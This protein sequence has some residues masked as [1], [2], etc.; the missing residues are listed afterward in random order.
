MNP[1]ERVVRRVDAFQQRH[2]VTSFAFGVVKK[3]G[4]DRAGS[5]AALIAYYSFLAI[6]PLLLL[7]VTILGFVA[8][9][10]TDFQHRL[11]HSAVADFPIIGNQIAKN[12]KSLRASGLGLA[13]SLIGL[14]WGSLG[15]T[16]AGQH[17]MAQVWNVPGVERPGFLPRL[18]RGAS[19]IGV[20]GLG[21]IATTIFS[22]FSAFNST[23]P[24]LRGLSML[25]SVLLNVA[26]S[27]AAFRLLT[28]RAIP[29]RKLVPGA[30]LAAL[31]WSVLQ[32]IGGYLVS[33]RL[34]Q[35]SEV[36]GLFAIVL[37]LL[38]WLSLGAQITLYAAELNVVR[39]RRLYPRSIVQPPL[40]GP[41]REALRQLAQQEERR[42][43]ERVRVD[44]VDEAVDTRD[45]QGRAG[46]G[47]P[48]RAPNAP[49]REPRWDERSGR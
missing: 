34:Q 25:V 37:G 9:H 29:S 47:S 43:E 24:A 49:T 23:V 11:V 39:A 27:L 2:R 36:Y 16:Q 4:D 44:F 45:G 22:G 7:L 15:F 46:A 6:F 8:Q 32:L 40:T 28:P 48:P 12:V 18:G 26:I 30:V 38:F 42:P 13:I 21:A 20:L 31:A 35:T 17:A 33:Q 5:L 10:N 19:I 14:A 3:F 41:D 1:V